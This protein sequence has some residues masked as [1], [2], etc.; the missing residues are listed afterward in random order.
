MDESDDDWSLHDI[1]RV[2]ETLGDVPLSPRGYAQSRASMASMS[3]RRSSAGFLDGSSSSL[4]HLPEMGGGVGGAGS[5]GMGGGGGRSR[6]QRRGWGSTAGAAGVVSAPSTVSD[7]SQ[8]IPSSPNLEAVMS[9]PPMSDE[10]IALSNN[11]AMDSR[12]SNTT[13]TSSLW[14]ETRSPSMVRPTSTTSIGQPTLNTNDSFTGQSLTGGSLGRDE[15]ISDHVME[16]VSAGM[17]DDNVSLSKAPAMPTLPSYSTTSRSSLKNST[18]QPSVTTGLTP[19]QR[20]RFENLGGAPSRNRLDTGGSSSTR[21]RLDSRG[22]EK[23]HQHHHHHHQADVSESTERPRHLGNGEAGSDSSWVDETDHGGGDEDTEAG[24]STTIDTRK[25]IVLW[26]GLELPYWLISWLPSLHRIS[27][28]VVTRAPCFICWGFRQPT[29]RTILARLNIL[30]AFLTAIQLASTVFLAV[31]SWNRPDEH[32]I[33]TLS[34]QE[35]SD[36]ANRG[37]VLFN[38]WTTNVYIYFTGML[39][40]VNFA[41][42]VLTMRVI[43][44][45]NLVGAVRYLWGK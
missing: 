3:S 1:D 10:H 38:V 45:V 29:D 24:D 7:A 37:P 27:T 30:V 35:A 15:S 41:A 6:F 31:V 8:N 14:S 12:R 4:R 20:A 16:G 26:G 22:V 28:L 23:Q 11:A 13:T 9:F 5:S 32:A 17:D 36:Q 19:H 21:V 33:H 18:H 2:P 25:V 44:N 34:D 43:R 42:A 40:F 39:A